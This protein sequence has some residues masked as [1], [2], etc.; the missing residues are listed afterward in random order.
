MD[1]DI[2]QFV[3]VK[4][5]KETFFPLPGLKNVRGLH[6]VPGF[7][8]LFHLLPPAGFKVYIN[9]DSSSQGRFPV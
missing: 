2:G 8:C 9:A 4:S 3:F 7:I 1:E 6:L 5:L